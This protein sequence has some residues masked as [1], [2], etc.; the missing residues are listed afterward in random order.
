MHEPDEAHLTHIA[1]PESKVAHGTI[2]VVHIDSRKTSAV[3]LAKK[4]PWKT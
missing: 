1:F 3:S 2:K 4:L